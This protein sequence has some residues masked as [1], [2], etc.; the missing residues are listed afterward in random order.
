M[1]KLN[2]IRAL[3]FAGSLLLQL[4]TLC[5]HA[6]G[7]AGDV[8]LSFDP[9]SAGTSIGNVQGI[10]VQPDGRV[11]IGGGSIAR[12]TANKGQASLP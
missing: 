7:A 1:K 8:D 5:F 12:I 6:R 3:I 9:G 11:I 4:G 10:A 2:L